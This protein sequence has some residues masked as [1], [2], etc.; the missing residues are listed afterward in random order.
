[1]KKTVTVQDQ[2][3]DCDSLQMNKMYKCSECSIVAMIH[4][5]FLDKK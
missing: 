2:R 5:C 4:E 1:M 3:K